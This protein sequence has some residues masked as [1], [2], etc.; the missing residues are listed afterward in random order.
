MRRVYALST[1][2]VLALGAPA[3]AQ[4]ATV[5]TASSV[6]PSPELGIDAGA[7]FGTG[8]NSR[9][10]VSIPVQQVRMGFFLSP[11]LSVEPTLRLTSFSG[12]GAPSVTVY[13]VGAGLLY[14]FSASRLTNQFYVRPFV[15]VEGSSGGG[16]SVTTFGFGG[17]LKIPVADRIASRFEANVART[18][19]NSTT[20][21]LLAGLS[22]YTH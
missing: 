19:G 15:S 14:H 17:G 1:V 9:T 20:I 22:F 8:N 10:V 2:A 11:A 3:T 16:G 13:D 5:H 18:D 6:S 4:R 7:T 12:G 21:G